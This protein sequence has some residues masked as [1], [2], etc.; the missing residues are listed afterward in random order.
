MVVFL[1]LIAGWLLWLLGEEA[2]NSSVMVRVWGGQL[3]GGFWNCD[4]V[5]F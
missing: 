3:E 2:A 4:E 5:G 1:V